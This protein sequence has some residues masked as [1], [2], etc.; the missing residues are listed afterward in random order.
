MGVKLA[1]AS[2]GSIELVPTNTASNFTVTVPAVTA[3]ALTDSAGILNIG[4]GQIYKDASGNVGIGTTSPTAL[5]DINKGSAGTLA[6]FTDGVNANFVIKTTSSVTTIGPSAG[7]TIL[8]FQAS[9]TERARIDTSGIFRVGTDNGAIQINPAGAQGY[10]ATISLSS[11]GVEFDNNSSIRDYYF[12]KSSGTVYAPMYAA[13]YNIS[14]YRLKEN[15]VPFTNAL[16]K[17]AQLKPSQFNFKADIK[18]KMPYGE[19]TVVG[20]IAHELAEVLPYAVHHEKDQ[21]D[22]DG[23]PVF[24]GIEASSLI[25]ILTAAIQEQQALIVQLQADVAALKGAQA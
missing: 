11:R 8:V 25:P 23:N 24:Q 16:A 2:G 13:S 7:S 17:V 22:T 21:V 19:S 1:A 14:D 20:F 10:T 5:L 15:I 9:N 18:T 4:S 12:T 6:N 3:T